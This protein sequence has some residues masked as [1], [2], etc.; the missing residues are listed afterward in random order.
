MFSATMQNGVTILTWITATETR[1]YGFEVQ[2]KMEADAWTTLGFVPGHG[3]TTWQQSYLYTD[4]LQN[5][6]ADCSRL[7]YRLKQVDFDG[8]YEYSPI[9]RVE[10]G[11]SPGSFALLTPYPNPAQNHLFIPFTVP[12][13]GAV[14]IRLHN[15]AGQT[16]LSVYESVQFGSGS[17]TV[18]ANISGIPNGMYF[19]ELTAD[20]QKQHRRVSITR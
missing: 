12:D 15:V 5:L 14:T 10:L 2:R 8:T 13:D 17:H 20:E 4:N 9:V 19:I 18:M 1:N 16:L 11:S 7:S 6:P 3:S